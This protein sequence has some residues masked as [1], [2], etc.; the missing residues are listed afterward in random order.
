MG[1][2]AEAADA[3][4]RTDG[5]TPATSEQGQAT[6]ENARLLRRVSVRPVCV[7]TGQSPGSYPLGSWQGM[8][9]PSCVIRTS[10][11]STG[12]ITSRVV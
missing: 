11:M 6:K 5:A 9:S 10:R 1:R 4:G 3:D 8:K 12:R 7:G 2:T